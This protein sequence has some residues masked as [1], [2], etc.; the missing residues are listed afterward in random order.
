MALTPAD[1][2]PA[3]VFPKELFMRPT[4]TPRLHGV[5]VEQPGPAGLFHHLHD[6]LLLPDANRV[7][8][9]GEAVML[10]WQAL[11]ID[12]GGEG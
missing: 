9:V 1:A 10:N 3:N 7:E 8:D 4:E 12:T 6:Q 11:W 5:N 2:Q